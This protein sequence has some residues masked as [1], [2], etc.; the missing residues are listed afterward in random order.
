M[1]DLAERSSLDRA[2]RTTL[3]RRRHSGCRRH[4][5]SY[6]EEATT[7]RQESGSY[8]EEDTTPK[9]ECGR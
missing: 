8:A 2:L 4:S 9:Q 7:P 5:G 3:R 1:S 6:A